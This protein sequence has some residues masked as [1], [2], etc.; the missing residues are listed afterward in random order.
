MEADQQALVVQV[1][2][3]PELP[4]HLVSF[5]KGTC[6]SRQAL[7]AVQETWI[8]FNDFVVREVS[9]EEVFSFPDAWKVRYG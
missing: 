4:A 9:A 5:A 7:T 8:M 6:A 2:T 3:T 1:Q